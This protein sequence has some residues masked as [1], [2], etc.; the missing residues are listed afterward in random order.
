[1]K[2]TSHRPLLTPLVSAL[3]SFP[4]FSQKICPSNSFRIRSY[5]QPSCNPFRFRSYENTG[6]WGSADRDLCKPCIE[7]QKRPPVSP[8]PATLTHSLSCNPFV[9]HSY[10]N[11]PDGGAALDLKSETLLQLCPDSHESKR[12]Y[13]RLRGLN[14]FC[15]LQKRRQD[16][17]SPEGAAHSQNW[18]CHWGWWDIIA[19][20]TLQMETS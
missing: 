14:T 6:G 3:T 4:S 13:S 18:L 1:M 5:R 15:A 12:P 19:R 11:P 2:S 7:A 20:L 10:A 9:C 8:F 16:R 17:R